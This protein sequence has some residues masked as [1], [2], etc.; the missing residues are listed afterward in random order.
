MGWRFSPWYLELSSSTGKQ[1]FFTAGQTTTVTAGLTLAGAGESNLLAI[2]ST[3]DG[4]EAFLDLDLAATGS[5]VDV[6]D[7]HAVDQSVTLNPGSTISGNATGW[8]RGGLVPALSLLGLAVLGAGLVLTGRR[9]L[10][11]RR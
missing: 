10:T 2:R 4:S 7:N 8:T 1:V 9:S 6:K 3:V 5:F 11:A